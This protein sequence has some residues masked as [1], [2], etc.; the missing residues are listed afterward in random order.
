MPARGIGLALPPWEPTAADLAPDGREIALTVD[1]AAEPGMM[2]RRDIVALDL[3]TRRKRVLTERTRTEGSGAGLSP[4]GSA[5]VF[6]SY[7]TE[8]SFNDRQS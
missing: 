1:L 7:S 3:D 5:L 2:N 8:R 6:H 4:D